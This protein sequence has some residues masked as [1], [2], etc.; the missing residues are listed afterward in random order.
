[1]YRH[2]ASLVIRKY[3]LKPQW[4]IYHTPAKMA[5]ILK[6]D[7]QVVGKRAEQLDTFPTGRTGITNGSATFSNGLLIPKIRAYT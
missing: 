7:N 1:M 6:I 5:K 4:G 2:Q 3:T